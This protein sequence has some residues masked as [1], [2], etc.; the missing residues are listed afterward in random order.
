[1]GALGYDAF[2]W[3][4]GELRPISAFDPEAD[5]RAAVEQPGYIFN[6]IFRPR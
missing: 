6:F 3:K 5:H 4:Q 2:V 1:V